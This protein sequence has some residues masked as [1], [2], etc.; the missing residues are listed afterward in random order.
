[1]LQTLYHVPKLLIRAYKY[2]NKTDAE[3]IRYIRKNLG[4]GD[5]AFDIGAHKGAYTYWMRRSVKDTGK[6]VCVEPQPKLVAYL[7]KVFGIFG[8]SNILI[9]DCA[10]SEKDSKGVITVDGPPGNIS[11]GARIDD[12]AKI[13]GK[14]DFHEIDVQIRSIDSIAEETGMEPK[15]VKIDVEGHELSVLK[16]MRRIFEEIRPI[17]VLECEK[18]H[19]SDHTVFDVFNLILEK[20]YSGYYLQDG[21]KHPLDRFDVQRDQWRYIEQGIRLDRNYINNFVFEPN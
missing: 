16:G 8:F 5:A 7:K 11:Q 13:R 10:V 21:H 19:L 1:M 6:I 2:L 17:I 12:Q 20:G 15:L 4:P 14:R 9:M 3:E 18:Q